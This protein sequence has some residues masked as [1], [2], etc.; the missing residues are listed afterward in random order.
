R[1][2]NTEEGSRC[3]LLSKQHKFNE[4]CCFCCCSPFTFLL[5]PKRPC[6]DC[7]YNV[8]KSCRTYSQS[9]RGY[10]CAAYLNILRSSPD[11]KQPVM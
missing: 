2:Q 11:L 4:H 9:E 6:L 1:F 7:H 10:I 5:N 8:S 3:L